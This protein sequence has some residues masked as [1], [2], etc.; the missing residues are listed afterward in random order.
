MVWLR[1]SLG[2][3]SALSILGA[4]A[5]HPFPPPSQEKNGGNFTLQEISSW[6]IPAQGSPVDAP[7]GISKK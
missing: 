2:Y 7:S 4:S 1:A 6:A 3:L 5:V